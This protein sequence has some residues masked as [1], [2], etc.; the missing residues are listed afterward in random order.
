MITRVSKSKVQKIVDKYYDYHHKYDMYKQKGN[1]RQ[2]EVYDQ[3]L[4]TMR[5][6]LS[7]LEIHIN[8][9]NSV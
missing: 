1:I 9:I 3:R 2:A 7:L 5:M 6:T 4:K 8:G